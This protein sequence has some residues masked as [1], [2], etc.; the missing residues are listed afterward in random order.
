[1]TEGL[2]QLH[3][4]GFASLKDVTLE[5]GPLTV[6]IGPNGSGKSNILRVLKMLESLREGFLQSF[7]ADAGGADALLHYGAK[8]TPELTSSPP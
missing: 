6:L 1:M 2:Q 4:E 8:Q 5:L 7:V 3:V